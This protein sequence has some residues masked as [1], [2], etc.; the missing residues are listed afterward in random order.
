MT[1]KKHNIHDTPEML[2][3]CLNKKLKYTKNPLA[4][5]Q[6]RPT[7]NAATKRRERIKSRKSRINS[8]RPSTTTSERSLY[9]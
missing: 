1:Q 8:I 2:T 4:N 5:P 9:S 7:V 3:V 6:R